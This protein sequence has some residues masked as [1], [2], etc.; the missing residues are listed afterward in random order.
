[1][2]HCHDDD[3]STRLDNS[4][5]RT[6]YIEIPPLSQPISAQVVFKICEDMETDSRTIRA[7]FDTH[8]CVD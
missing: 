6:V 5:G 3:D 8:F 7:M 1:M 2:K 4:Q